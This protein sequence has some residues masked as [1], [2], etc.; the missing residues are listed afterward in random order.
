LQSA[1]LRHRG[2]SPCHRNTMANLRTTC[3]SLG[4]KPASQA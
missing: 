4:W 2:L 3:S 1:C